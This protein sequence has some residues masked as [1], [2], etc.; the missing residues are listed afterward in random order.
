M[1]TL[2]FESFT[3]LWPKVID[4]GRERALRIAV[5]GD[6]ARAIGMAMAVRQV[7]PTAAVTL[8]AGNRRNLD[9]S[10]VDFRNFEFK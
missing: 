2:P 6:G 4:L 3:A 7:L 5:L 8:V 1:F 10:L 9:E